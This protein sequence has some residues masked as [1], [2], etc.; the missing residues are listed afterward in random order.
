MKSKYWVERNRDLLYNQQLGVAERQLAD[1]YIRCLEKT[2]IDLE[3]LYQQIISDNVNGR[4]VIASDLYKYNRYYELINHLQE[5]LSALGIKENEIYDERLTKM[6]LNNSQLTTIELDKPFLNN[7]FSPIVDESR[8]KTAINAVWCNDGMN[9]SERVWRNKAFLTE[10]IKQ[11]L[12]DC[13]ARGASKDD[14]VKQL[15]KDFNVGF[16]QADRIARTELSHIQNKATVDK[17]AE[18]GVKY[19]QYYA[20][21]DD[22]TCDEECGEL[23]GKIFPVDDTEHLPPQHPNCRCTVLAV[24]E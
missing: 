9:W 12:V 18:A 8:I 11:G 14:L 3:L 16:N 1:E 5:N 20:T 22:K 4:E 6:Y 13:V 2:K 15:M 7:A 24:L 21:K 10:R 19:Y 23:D 17:Y